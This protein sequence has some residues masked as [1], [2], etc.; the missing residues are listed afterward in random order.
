MSGTRP[1]EDLESFVADHLDEVEIPRRAACHC[2]DGAERKAVEVHR[3]D[4]E[5]GVLWVCRCGRRR[6]AVYDLDEF[7]EAMGVEHP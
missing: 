5:F 3:A 6:T 4:R 7:L 1:V 2:G